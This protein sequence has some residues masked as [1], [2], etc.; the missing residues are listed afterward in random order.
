MLIYILVINLIGFLSMGIDKKQAIQ[1]RERIPEIVLIS[2]AFLGGGIASFLGMFAFHHK[3]K[4][5]KFRILIPL[6]ILWN[7][8]LFLKL[9]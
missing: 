1:N 7:I 2:I 8:Y 3:T 6:S 5:W 4:K 9:I